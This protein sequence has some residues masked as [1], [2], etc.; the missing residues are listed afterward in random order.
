MHDAEGG[1]AVGH[2]LDEDAEGE[3][4]VD[5]VERLGLAAVAPGLLVDRVDV[6]GAAGDLGPDPG[7]VELRAEAGRHVLDVALAGEAGGVETGG[8]LLVALGLEEA[9]GEVLELPLDLPDAKAGRERGENLHRLAGDAALLLGGEG[10]Q[11]AHVVQPVAELDE[12][13][14]HVGGHGEQHLA[15][16]LGLDAATPFFGHA[17]G[18]AAELGQPLDELGRV[19]AEA[20]GDLLVGD[21]AILLHVVQEGGD[22]GGL[23]ELKAG[24]ELRHFKRVGDVGI[25]GAAHLALVALLRERIR[26]GNE[27]DALGG[28]IASDAV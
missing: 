19:L 21:A 6:L 5:L 15:E 8:D 24:D 27:L 10:V 22:E 1:V 23:V 14:A 16:V 18:E 13:H 12:D 25:A 17:Q 26:V 20:L 9:E 7:V 2:V 28:Q 4:V 3:Q 11:R